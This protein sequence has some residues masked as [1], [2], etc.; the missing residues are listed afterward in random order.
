MRDVLNK[1]HSFSDYSLGGEGQGTTKLRQNTHPFVHFTEVLPSCGG[2]DRNPYME[3][4]PGLGMHTVNY[5]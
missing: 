5:T 3:G 2:F 4:K 1:M